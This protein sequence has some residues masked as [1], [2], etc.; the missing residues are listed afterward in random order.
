MGQSI[1]FSFFGGVSQDGSG[2]MIDFDKVLLELARWL[3]PIGICLLAEGACLEECRRMGSLS[4]YRYEKVKIWWRK[5]FV[6][7]LLDGLAVA[8]VLLILAIVIDILGTTEVSGEVWKALILWFAHIMTLMSF[9]AVL[10]L[11][12][13]RRITPALLLLLEGFTFLVG[14]QSIG[15]AQF[16]YGMWGMYF[17]S[18]WHYGETGVTVLASLIAEGILFVFSYLAGRVLLGREPLNEWK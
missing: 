14:F 4:C 9:F 1:F 18:K 5:R 15:K 12:K 6:K 2:W 8:A 16:M 10:D 3:L 11:T 17:Q 7:S 13:L